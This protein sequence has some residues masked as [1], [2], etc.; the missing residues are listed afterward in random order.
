MG[1]RALWKDKEGGLNGVEILHRYITTITQKTTPL[2]SDT[3]YEHPVERRE[4]SR[5][6]C[7]DD[8][9]VF[10]YALADQGA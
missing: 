6:Y 7:R 9:I 5:M 4:G 8:C 3:S 2:G 10:Y 1:P